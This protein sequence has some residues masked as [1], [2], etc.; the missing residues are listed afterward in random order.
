VDRQLARK[1]RGI[2]RRR[3]TAGLLTKKE[4][5]DR[6]E[7]LRSAPRVPGPKGNVAEAIADVD[8]VIRDIGDDQDYEPALKRHRKSSTWKVDPT[9]SRRQI[10]FLSLEEATEAWVLERGE[11]P[12]GNSPWTQEQVEGI[13]PIYEHGK[14]EF[15]IFDGL[16]PDEERPPD[17]FYE[18]QIEE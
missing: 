3:E 13:E 11:D 2:A 1:L 18:Y 16:D 4:L 17:G 14:L 9:R 8:K 10:F 12:H 6:E 15:Y 7:Q 5:E